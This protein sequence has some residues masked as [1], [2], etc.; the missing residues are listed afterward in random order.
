MLRQHRISLFRRNRRNRN[1]LNN[2][3]IRNNQK[4][5]NI[6]NTDKILWSIFCYLKFL[7]YFCI[8]KTYS[9]IGSLDAMKREWGESPQQTRC[10]ELSFTP[11]STMPLAHLPG[12]R[13]SGRQQ[14]QKTCR[15]AL[16]SRGHEVLVAQN[17]NIH[18]NGLSPSH[19][20][21]WKDQHEKNRP[22]MAHHACHT[23]MCSPDRP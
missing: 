22:D 21:T 23:D 9:V 5:R 16:P 2:R 17:N 13:S 7:N 11:L 4:I 6:Q 1:I 12:R 15:Y 18:T 8:V 20:S 14:S 19:L 10:C 3:S